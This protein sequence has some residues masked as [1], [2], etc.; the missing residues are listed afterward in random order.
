MYIAP[1]LW[2][3]LPNS[4][5]NSKTLLTFESLIRD[6]IIHDVIWHLEESQ[7]S[8]FS[9]WHCY[10]YY[11]FLYYTLTIYLSQYSRPSVLRS[12]YV[13]FCLLSWWPSDSCICK[14][15]VPHPSPDYTPLLFGPR[16]ST[17]TEE[18]KVKTLWTLTT[19]CPP[20]HQPVQSSCHL[21]SVSVSH[22]LEWI[23]AMSYHFKCALPRIF[24]NFSAYLLIRISIALLLISLWHIMIL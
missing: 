3:M 12:T 24:S 6:L 16:T 17:S 2:N 20:W 13:F 10:H 4:V 15:Q 18:T 22:H 9:T 11:L 14:L 23:Y 1:H 19:N 8:Q 21:V 5:R 7:L